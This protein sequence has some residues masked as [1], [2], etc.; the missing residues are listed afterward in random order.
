MHEQAKA[1]NIEAEV[2]VG[3]DA[4][5]AET[6]WMDELAQVEG[7]RIIHAEQHLG[8]TRIQ[9]HCLGTGIMLHWKPHT[10]ST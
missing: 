3:D 9:I 10:R 5:T 4:S 1:E 7:I 2:V 6:A 8:R